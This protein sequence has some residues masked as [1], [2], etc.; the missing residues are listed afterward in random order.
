MA[1]TPSQL[2]TVG[3]PGTLTTFDMPSSRKRQSVVIA[4]PDS[5]GETLCV[6]LPAHDSPDRGSPL[7]IGGY[8]SSSVPTAVQTGDRVNAWFSPNGALN[9]VVT[10]DPSVCYDVERRAIQIAY[11]SYNNAS[12]NVIVGGIAGWRIKVL[13]VSCAIAVYGGSPGTVY[14]SD[15]GAAFYLARYAAA[16]QSFFFTNGGLMFY[17]TGV[18]ANL[19][20]IADAGST[21]NWSIT[22]LYGQN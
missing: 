20:V 1:L 7:K 13:A 6:E 12:L 8:A 16:G 9:T 3:L 14:L 17:Q 22:Y 5:A 21:V 4:D 2:N 19:G 15:G 10:Q 11:A 18:A